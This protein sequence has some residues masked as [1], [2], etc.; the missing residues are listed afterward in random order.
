MAPGPR[1]TKPSPSCRTRGCCASGW[2]LS[3][4]SPW[5]SCARGWRSGDRRGALFHPPFL[6]GTRP[7]AQKKSLHASEQDRPDVAAARALW[8][9][10]QS[11]PTPERP[12]FIDETWITTNMVRRYGRAPRGRRLIAGVPHGHWQTSTF[13]AALRHEA[14]TA[15]CVIDGPI[16]GQTFRRIPL[17]ASGARS[18][19]RTST[20]R[21]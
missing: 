18:G 12:V 11:E 10:H 15:P 2:P 20:R 19:A 6:E 13:L 7:D 1:G 17:V 4:T 16:N 8:R 5:T 21:E 14:I 9:A 3:L